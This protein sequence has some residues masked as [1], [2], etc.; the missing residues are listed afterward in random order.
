MSMYF[1]TNCRRPYPKDR[2]PYR[3]PKCGGLYDIDALPVFDPGRVDASQ[4]GIWPYRHALGLPAD[5]PPVSLGEGNTPLVW[6]E[7]SGRQVAFKL[8]FLNPTG[9]FKDRG[10]APLVSFLRTRGVSEVV[11]DSSGNAGASLAA[12]AA[13][14]GIR[15]Q[16]FIPAYASGPKRMQIEAYG[17]QVIAVPG[18]RS[19]T[20][21]AVQ[22]AADEGAV[23][24]SH[25]W[26]PQGLLGYATIAF[27]LVEQLGQTPGTVV[28]PVGQGSLLLGVGR[29][30]E[31]LRRAGA[32]AHLPRLI[33]VQVDACAPLWS[34]FTYGSL[35][36]ETIS[37]RETAA[38][39]VRIR[40]PL[41]GDAVLKLT[42]ASRGRF[43]VVQEENILPGRDQ[44]SRQGLFVEPTSAIVWDALA[45]IL[46]DAPPPVVAV[47]TGSGLKSKL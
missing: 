16:I 19:H 44:L 24:A 47:L 35:G 1:C 34:A 38:E 21:D 30:F 13:A 26:M 40:Y 33:G 2:I 6:R 32:I 36:L 46:D 22:R 14:Y 29:G 37:E 5:A 43:V 42:A 4:P 3:C 17:A 25:A 41:R 15:A 10:A 12:Y 28:I 27:E 45:Q 18:L 9:S 23:Y 20:S 7:I 39:G 31:M 11:E 8:E